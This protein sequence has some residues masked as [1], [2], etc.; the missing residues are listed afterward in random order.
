MS[1]FRRI[2]VNVIEMACEIVFVS[3]GV[4]PRSALANATLRSVARLA[5]IR[6]SRAHAKNALLIN[7]PRGA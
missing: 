6:S 3:Q 2:E 5:E 7:R 1:M 4:F